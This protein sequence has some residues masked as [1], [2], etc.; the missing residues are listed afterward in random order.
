MDPA[1]RLPP[2]ILD[3]VFSFLKSDLSALKASASAHSLLSKLVERHLYADITVCNLEAS[4]GHS[5]SSTQLLK[6][7]SDNPHI[8]NYVYGLHILLTNRFGES[9]TMA[10]I[11]GQL[12]NLRRVILESHRFPWE[13]LMKQFRC[14]FLECL[15]SPS[16]KEVSVWGLFGFPLSGL[17]NCSGLKYL[18]VDDDCSH[19]DVTSN[20]LFPPLE[21]LSVS[22]CRT[23]TGFVA[24]AKQGALRS[25][26]FQATSRS[27]FS[28]LPELLE[29]CSGTLTSLV[30]GLHKTR[31]YIL[32]S[33]LSQ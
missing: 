32:I 21:S 4:D 3:H 18:S 7:L 30:L 11:F 29:A 8:A 15:R 13:L 9:S 6:L 22:N 25:L 12:P 28:D 26:E 16:I 31:Q 20:H 19:F 24:W 5:F 27:Y 1:L 10:P 17:S 2:E 14:A 23:L 33:P